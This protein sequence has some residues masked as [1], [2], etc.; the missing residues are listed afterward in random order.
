MHSKIAHLHN[1]PNVVCLFASEPLGPKALAKRKEKEKNEDGERARYYFTP[2]F[3][4]FTPSLAQ[5]LPYSVA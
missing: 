4:R 2:M 1:L 3:A 5:R